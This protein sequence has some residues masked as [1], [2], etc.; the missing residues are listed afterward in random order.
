MSRLIFISHKMRQYTYHI[1]KECGVTLC[2]YCPTDAP[3]CPSVR[4]VHH[5]NTLGYM[6]LIEHSLLYPGS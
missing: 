6:V 1:R 4:M 2:H 5:S 3:L